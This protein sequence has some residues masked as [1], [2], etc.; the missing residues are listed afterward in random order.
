MTEERRTKLFE[1]ALNSAALAADS[2]ASVSNGRYR[3][4]RSRHVFDL[5]R[6]GK[7]LQPIEYPKDVVDGVLDPILDG[8]A[9]S[10]KRR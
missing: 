5:A 2:G 7:R 4:E 1:A 3:P 6:N 8:L 10:L 9:E